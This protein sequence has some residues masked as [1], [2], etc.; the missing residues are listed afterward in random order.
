M[1]KVMSDFSKQYTFWKG[2]LIVREG[3]K[4]KGIYILSSGSFEIWLTIKPEKWKQIKDP[5]KDI[6]N[7]NVSPV[8]KPI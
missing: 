7:Q 4:L 6:L 2:D 3:Q 1:L 8:Y 5:V